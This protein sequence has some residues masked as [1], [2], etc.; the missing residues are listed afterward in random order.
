[1]LGHSIEDPGRVE[2]DAEQTAGLGLLPLETRF[3]RVKVTEQVEAV[4]ATSSFLGATGIGVRGYFIHMGRTR[5]L[6]EDPAFELAGRH[7]GAV[8]RNGAVVGTMIHGL[9]ESQ[10]LRNALV[11]SL[12]RRA[13]LE[14]VHAE[15]VRV[16]PAQEYDRLA[17][18]VRDAVDI[19]R[20][21]EIMGPAPPV[22][23]Q[24]GT[25]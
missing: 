9:F 12:G 7:D 8:G 20:I 3:D 15:S 2:S 13:G 22:R 25:T 16:D 19:E 1:M 10:S 5:A 14:A 21:V 17:S 6:S 18:T 4:T 23:A 11:R 24:R